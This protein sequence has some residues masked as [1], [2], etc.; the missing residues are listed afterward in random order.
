MNLAAALLLAGVSRHYGWDLLSDPSS[1]TLDSKALGG[2]ASLA[3]LLTVYRL[4]LARRRA[5]VVRQGR[6]ADRAV[7]ACIHALAVGCC[8]RSIYL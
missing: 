6:P 4:A 2:A 8:A 5:D 7:H 3:L 1:R